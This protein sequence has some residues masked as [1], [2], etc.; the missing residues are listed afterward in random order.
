M[1]KAPNERY[2]KMLVTRDHRPLHIVPD[3]EDP[4]I[5]L[6]SVKCW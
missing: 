6:A 1:L 2:L 4:T 5:H 3:H